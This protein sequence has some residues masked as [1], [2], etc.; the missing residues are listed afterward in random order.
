MLVDFKS[1]A[2]IAAW[3]RLHP[4]RHGPMLRALRR[5]WPQFEPVIEDAAKLIWTQK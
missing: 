1:S 3:Y 4:A 5:L 2:S